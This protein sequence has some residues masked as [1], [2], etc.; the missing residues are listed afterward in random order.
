MAGSSPTRTNPVVR[1]ALLLTCALAASSNP[2]AGTQLVVDAGR[3][4]DSDGAGPVGFAWTRDGVEIPG[5]SG[6][7]YTFT[8]A[9]VGSSLACVHLLGT[10][11]SDLPSADGTETPASPSS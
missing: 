11:A 5:A 3:I 2:E 1:L 6:P 9:D 10:N 4:Q 8:S 7:I